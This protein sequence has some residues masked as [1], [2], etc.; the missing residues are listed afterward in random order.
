MRYIDLKM[1]DLGL[2]R[3]YLG[4]N[5]RALGWDEV[6]VCVRIVYK[7]RLDHYLYIQGCCIKA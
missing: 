5:R 1:R 3:R 6:D 7:I 2:E 4:L